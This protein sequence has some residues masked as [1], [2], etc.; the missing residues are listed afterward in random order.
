MVLRQ[1]DIHMQKNKARPLSYAYTEI[2][3]KWTQ[4]P[5]VKAKTTKLSEKNIVLNPHHLGL[6]KAFLD[7]TQ[8]HEQK[9]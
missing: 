5:D 4:D 1:Q 3:S 8:K 2:V 6:G 7:T 9:N